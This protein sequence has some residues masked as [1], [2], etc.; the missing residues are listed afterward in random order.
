MRNPGGRRNEI[1]KAAL[2]C[3]LERGFEGTTV[4]AIRARSGA[5]TG[6]IY[7]V[8]PSKD[9]IA[10]ALYLEI[11]KQYQGELLRELQRHHTAKEG[12]EAL[13]RFHLEWT[14]EHADETRFL[15][16]AREASQV[17]AAE[18]NI[19]EQNRKFFGEVLEWLQ[20]HIR[21]GAVEAMPFALFFSVIL[22]PAQEL[23]REWLAGRTKV[24]M[25]AAIPILAAAAWRAVEKRPAPPPK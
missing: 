1:L 25:R 10:A 24:D 7:H 3:F 15:V 12:I 23:L 21:Q 13:V 19:V 2:E 16:V 11:L 17:V 22:G 9:A 5:S 6:S 8:F 20:P 14:Q 4:A 18:A